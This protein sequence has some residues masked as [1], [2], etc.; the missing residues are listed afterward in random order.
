MFRT[1]P[2]D[3][4][5]LV[6]RLQQYAPNFN[7]PVRYRVRNPRDLIGRIDTLFC[8]ERAL[9]RLDL[10]VTERVLE[11]P[12]VFRVLRAEQG[13]DVLEFGCSNSLL[14]LQIASMGL[15][16]T[17]V[18]LRP[19]PLTHD[20]LRFLQGDLF[21]L[22]L[23]TE[24]FDSVVAVS[25]V[26]HVGLGGYG[27]E[28]SP[29]RNDEAII[30]VFRTLLRPGGQLILTVPFGSSY[31]GDG[32]RIYDGPDLDRLLLGFGVQH[33]ELYRRIGLY[34]WVESERTEMSG[35]EWRARGMGADG[36]ALVN[37]VKPG[38]E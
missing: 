35:V 36:V 6:K 28:R 17:G 8:P 29:E 38:P 25:A 2:A 3:I 30:R 10:I 33:I 20:N 22:D 7:P 27:E 13:N 24:S 16:V 19:Y 21:D 31:V 26:E 34:R 9:D 18:D 14:A 11:W 12:F 15:R 4:W 23:G 5:R 1:R 37:A 32:Y